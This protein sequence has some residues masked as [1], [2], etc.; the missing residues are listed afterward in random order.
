MF[1]QILERSIRTIL[2]EEVQVV[3]VFERS[4]KLHSIRMFGQF[5]ADVSFAVDCLFLIISNYV[6]DLNLL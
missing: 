2:S 6:R 4:V 5:T 3:G 1:E